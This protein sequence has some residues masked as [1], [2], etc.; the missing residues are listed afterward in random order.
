MPRIRSK[1][2]RALLTPAALHILLS[3]ADEDR[4]G[5]AIRGVIEERTGGQLDLGPGTLYEALHRM[6]ESKWI[7]VVEGGD[8][9]KK[10][11]TLTSAGREELDVELRRLDEILSF[12]R[13]HALF[14]ATRSVG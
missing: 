1:N 11:Y 13:D 12:A 8:G 7:R 6:V 10:T 9:R 2:P 14:P 4:H 3:L 5:Y